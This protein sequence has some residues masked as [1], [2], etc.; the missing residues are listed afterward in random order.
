MTAHAD[1]VERAARI[2]AATF[3]DPYEWDELTDRWREMC[4]DCARQVLATAERDGDQ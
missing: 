4:R 1:P 2:I 3:A